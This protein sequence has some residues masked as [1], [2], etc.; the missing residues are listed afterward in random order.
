MKDKSFPRAVEVLEGA[1]DLA[2]T[3]FGEETAEACEYRL[4]GSCTPC[5]GSFEDEYCSESMTAGGWLCR[6]TSRVTQC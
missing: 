2:K 3:K 4:A 1:L 6:H 5:T